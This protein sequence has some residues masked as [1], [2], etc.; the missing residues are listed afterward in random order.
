MNRTPSEKRLSSLSSYDSKRN[1][2]EESLSLRLSEIVPSPKQK[3]STNRRNT[4]VNLKAL[5]KEPELNTAH[6][7]DKKTVK[8]SL[9]RGGPSVLFVNFKYIFSVSSVTNAIEW[10]IPLRNLIYVEISRQPNQKIPVMVI[11]STSHHI[12]ITASL[13]SSLERIVDCIAALVR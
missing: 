10:V 3:I 13:R 1:P 12:R 4:V 8:T 5:S 2:S 11:V 7:N 6:K 9:L